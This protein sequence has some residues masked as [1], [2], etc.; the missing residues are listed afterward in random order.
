MKTK[1][2]LILV[3]CLFFACSNNKQLTKTKMNRIQMV[4]LKKNY[5]A[6]VGEQLYYSITEH[7]SV[8]KTAEYSIANE[9]IVAFVA[10]EEKPKHEQK[11]NTPTPSG[12][13]EAI[14]NFVFEAKQ[15]GETT[16]S[17]MEYF[18]GELKSTRELTIIV[19]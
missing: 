12:A 14:I 1:F 18:R 4:P 10:R 2:S 8:G 9:K 6:K 3:C 13:D 5:T 11:P 7:P 17:F 15:A 19:E 16:I